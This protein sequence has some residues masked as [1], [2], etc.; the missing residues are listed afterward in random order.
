MLDKDYKF[1]SMEQ[2]SQVTSWTQ[3]LCKK[4]FNQYWNMGGRENAFLKTK[5]KM[6]KVGL[7]VLLSLF[8]FFV[9]IW[10][11]IFYTNILFSFC[12]SL[13]KK[14]PLMRRCKESKTN[15]KRKMPRM[16]MLVIAHFSCPCS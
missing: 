10:F 3:L 16:M 5:K 13:R 11:S 12:S 15:A 9:C 4:Y 1:L 8:L 2:L 6:E 14:L 7:R